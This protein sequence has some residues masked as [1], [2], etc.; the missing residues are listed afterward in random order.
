MFWWIK[1]TGWR[2]VNIS[3]CMGAS[4]LKSHILSSCKHTSKASWDVNV[5]FLSSSHKANVNVRSKCLQKRIVHCFPG[6]RTSRFGL[7]RVQIWVQCFHLEL[8]DDCVCMFGLDVGVQC[9]CTYEHLMGCGT[10][11]KTGPGGSGSRSV[12]V[13]RETPIWKK[14]KR[15]M[16][17]DDKQ[18]SLQIKGR[19]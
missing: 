4:S 10:A 19:Q 8:T 16:W 7:K 18:Q 6:F 12:W 15:R 5:N 1:W 11:W 9:M 17:F 13:H 2:C 3:T 14:K